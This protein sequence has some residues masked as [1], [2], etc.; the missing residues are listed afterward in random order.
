MFRLAL[1]GMVAASLA[2]CASEE[3][4]QAEWDGFVA[5]HA[6]CE[7]PEDCVLV[8][9]GCPLGCADAIQSDAAQEATELAAKL[10]SRYERG[11]RACDYKCLAFTADC[12]AG[13][14]VAVEVDF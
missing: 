12:Q 5:E 2:A 8:Y 11:G 6:T 1:L 13:T 7:V 3:K 14:C 10:V 9:P 4:L